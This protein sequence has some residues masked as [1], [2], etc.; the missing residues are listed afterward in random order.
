[1]TIPQLQ[2]T[3]LAFDGAVVK[4]AFFL[5]GAIL[6][7]ILLSFLVRY[8]VFIILSK[9]AKTS[10]LFV[11]SSVQLAIAIGG[12]YA[13][14][15]YAGVSPVVVLAV[16]AII[17]AGISLSMDS[18]FQSF[19]G[20]LQIVLSDRI[21]VGEHITVNGITGQVRSIDLFNTTMQINSMGIVTV[22]NKSV[23]DAQL[24][25]HSRLTEGVELSILVPMFNNHDRQLA[26]ETIVSSLK[27]L[28]S[29]HSNVKVVHSWT[30]SSEQYTVI[31]KALDYTKRRDVASE[32][33]KRVTNG[34]EGVGLPVGV[35]TFI[36]KV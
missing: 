30:T 33:S 1:M 24:I 32:V 35:V 11:S 13:I 25:N 14:L 5:A 26:I 6:G 22:S 16:L 23:N 7:L 21:K 28:E 20:G 17:T 8:L 34:L 12:L 2:L 10:A 29:I 36:K 18:A 3:L 9:I 31:F 15:T 19:L 27:G 4:Q